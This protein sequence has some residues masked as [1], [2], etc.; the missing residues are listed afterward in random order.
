LSGLL[1]SCPKKHFRYLAPPSGIF[2]FECEPEVQARATQRWGTSELL[3]QSDMRGHAALL[4]VVTAPPL[5]LPS[6]RLVRQVLWD[7]YLNIKM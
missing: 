4:S 3:L 6:A 2:P 7:F 1:A 5:L